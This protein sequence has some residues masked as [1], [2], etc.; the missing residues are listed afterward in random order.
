MPECINRYHFRQ[1]H[2]GTNRMPRQ[3]TTS[4]DPLMRVL[5]PL[6]PA[7]VKPASRGTGQNKNGQDEAQ[8][9][10][11]A[12]AMRL[13][14]AGDAAALRARESMLTR[15]AAQ[16]E[17]PTIKTSAKRFVERKS[18]TFLNTP[19][20]VDGRGRFTQ[21]KADGPPPP[22]AKVRELHD[23]YM[24]RCR[25]CTGVVRQ[26]FMR[27]PKPAVAGSI[28]ALADLA[29]RNYNVFKTTPNAQLLKMVLAA[30]SRK[31]VARYKH[32]VPNRTVA[33][34]DSKPLV[35]LESHNNLLFHDAVAEKSLQRSRSPAVCAVIH[36]AD[37]VA[38]WKC[39]EDKAHRP[40]VTLLDDLKTLFLARHELA[41]RQ[42]TLPARKAKP[43]VEQV[44]KIAITPLRPATTRRQPEATTEV[45]LRPRVKEQVPQHQVSLER[46]T[47][48][49]L[50]PHAITAAAAIKPA[51]I[52]PATAAA[53]QSLLYRAG[54]VWERAV[55][56]PVPAFL[57]RAARR[58]KIIAI[59][60]VNS[61]DGKTALVSQ[62]G[63]TLA[64][65]GEQVLMLDMDY[66][67]SLTDTCFSAET[68]KQLR[69]TG[70]T[71]VRWLE[72]AGRRGRPLLECMAR[73]SNNLWAVA[74]DESLGVW[75]A[76]ERAAWLVQ[77]DP[78]DVRFRLRGELHGTDICQRFDWII[79]DCSRRLSAAAINALT[80]SDYL[81]LAGASQASSQAQVSQLLGWLAR[82]NV[83]TGACRGLSMLGVVNMS[84]TGEKPTGIAAAAVDAPE[85]DWTRAVSPAREASPSPR[86]S[87]GVYYFGHSVPRVAVSKEAVAA[88]SRSPAVRPARGALVN[89]RVAAAPMAALTREIKD[90]IAAR[91]KRR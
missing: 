61:G 74:S 10:A 69:A 78:Y 27:W 60:D 54:R 7:S 50:K 79:I 40:A 59:T 85:V 75:E 84:E 32:L 67:G 89:S 4:R 68:R 20:G 57:A 56:N 44:R 48:A 49:V 37:T 66:R 71:V 63:A 62:L 14:L 80:V 16:P 3:D 55:Q 70:R 13:I 64:A 45:I 35:A 23:V 46:P 29:L 36:T 53:A 77:K 83:L 41:P 28:H 12:E 25:Y 65:Q 6:A 34:L 87:E 42:S 5:G 24:A 15:P 88:G 51:P 73:V 76:R 2:F 72:S 9:A 30:I 26:R 1:S 90:R 82:L 52:K 18:L 81:M 33:W 38:R 11:A 31:T 86:W 21:E 58:A 8:S 43:Q 22:R 17:E 91:G 19:V 39:A 47:V